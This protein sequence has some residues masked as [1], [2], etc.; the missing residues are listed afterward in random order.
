MTSSCPGGTPHFLD[1]VGP[2]GYIRIHSGGG[3]IKAPIIRRVCGRSKPS[4]R[5]QTKE[6]ESPNLV[7]MPGVNQHVRAFLARLYVN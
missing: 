3:R 4:G 2:P 5:L 6:I 1:S 7:P